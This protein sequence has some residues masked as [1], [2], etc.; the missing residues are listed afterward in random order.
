MPFWKTR[1]DAPRQFQPTGRSGQAFGVFVMKQSCAQSGRGELMIYR[2]LLSVVLMLLI[3]SFGTLALGQEPTAEQEERVAELEESL[4]Y[5]DYSVK[6]Y[7]LS[8][9]GGN[10]SGASYLENPE[11]GP[12]TVLTPGAG[13][14]IAYNGDVLWESTAKYENGLNIYDAAHKEIEPGP[15]FGGRVGIYISQDFHLDL[16][17]TYATGNAITTMLYRPDPEDRTNSSRITVDEDSGF[18]MVKGGLALMYDAKPATMFGIEP[19]LG[20]GLGGI[21]NRYSF[22]GDKTALYLE[23]NFGLS[24]E[25]FDNFDITGQ[26]DVTT[27]AY[28]VDELGYSNMVN[29]ATFSIGVSWFIDVVPHDVRAA[30]LA[31]LEAEE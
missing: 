2:T 18:K 7:R 1:I 27:F 6:G 16:L 11:L 15:A 8:F 19:R 22:L 3:L 30:H 5:D 4:K 21:I 10:F 28:E 24:Y 14:I 12:R 25:L 17:G 26:V 29:Y 9:W 23:G 31:E 20:F 13:D